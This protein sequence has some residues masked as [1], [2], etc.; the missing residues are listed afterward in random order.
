MKRIAASLLSLTFLLILSGCNTNQNERIQ[1]GK[2]LFSDDFS[3]G[4]NP[5]NWVVE[6]DS[7]PKSRVYVENGALIAD[8]EGGVT[9]WYKHELE[10][11]YLIEYERT[12]VMEEGVNDRL[13]DLNQFWSASDPNNPNLFTRTGKFEEYHELSQYYIGVGGNYNSTTRFRKYD[14]AGERIIIG[15]KNEAPYLLEANIPYKVQILVKD[16]LVRFRMNDTDFFEYQD[17]NPLTK[18]YFGFRSTWS[19]HKI[20]HIH[21]YQLNN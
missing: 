15:E 17:P 9:I 11:N 19:R 6:M 18:G 3:E 13:S 2:L 21:I 5:D 20:D 12:V 16:G 8:T 4:L 10:G 14:G 1:K 7:T